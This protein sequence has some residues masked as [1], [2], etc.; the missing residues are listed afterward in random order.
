MSNGGPID[1]D[2][3]ETIISLLRE[4]VAWTKLA[5]RPQVAERFTE[6]LNSDQKRL[7]YEYSDG[8]RGVREVSRLT[9][10]SKNLV[11]AWWQD[12]DELGIME[13]SQ[14]VAGRRQRMVCLRALGIQVPALPKQEEE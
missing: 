8:E 4:L 13:Q 5:I 14:S 11:S 12:W 3:A 10:V 1:G 2:Q 9:R 7:V 6:I